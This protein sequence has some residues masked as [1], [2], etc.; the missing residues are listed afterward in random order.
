MKNFN[1][2][3]VSISLLFI[4][5]SSV[6]AQ[7]SNIENCNDRYNNLTYDYFYNKNSRV[8]VNV[9]RVI[10]SDPKCSAK[11]LK[12]LTQDNDVAVWLSAEE[13]LKNQ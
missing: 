11:T 2:A 12:I 10:A 1:K 7:T 6:H 4:T 13:N 5:V 3:L 8:S 9:K